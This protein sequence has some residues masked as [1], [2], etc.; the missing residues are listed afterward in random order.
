LIHS[1]VH[2]TPRSASSAIARRSFA[3]SLSGSCSASRRYLTAR[4][5]LIA[6][7]RSLSAPAGLAAFEHLPDLSR[8]PVRQRMF[9]EP[10]QR[11]RD[12]SQF[13]PGFATRQPSGLSQ[14][15]GG[16]F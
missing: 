2:K 11:N 5:L 7:S 10:A 12:L 8:A 9:G 13:V 14:D 3:L 6:N 15:F 1:A 4:G 16:V